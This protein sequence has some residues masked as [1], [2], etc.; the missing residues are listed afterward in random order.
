MTSRTSDLPTWPHVQTY[1]ATRSPPAQPSKAYFNIKRGPYSTCMRP[2]TYLGV[3]G[4]ESVKSAD[5]HATRPLRT[6]L[7]SAG[8]PSP[9]LRPP[10]R[11]E[12][13]LVARRP[14]LKSDETVGPAHARQTKAVVP[15]TKE[16]KYVIYRN[17]SQLAILPAAENRPN[18]TVGRD[19]PITA[20]VPEQML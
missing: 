5:H 16:T 17:S 10:A 19:L 15:G 13:V 8:S 7:A 12:G 4:Q 11:P 1:I 2:R 20:S 3:R 18:V 14:A 9:P 6:Y